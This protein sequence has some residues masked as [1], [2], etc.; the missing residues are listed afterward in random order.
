MTD[1]HT[2]PSKPLVKQLLIN[3]L[4][5]IPI[6]VIPPCI[7][8]G[9]VVSP[10]TNAFST[11]QHCILRFTKSDSSYLP[12]CKV[13]AARSQDPSAACFCFSHLVTLAYI[14]EHVLFFLLHCKICSM[15][16]FTPNI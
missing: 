4:C 9:V 8:Q 2:S 13:G 14:R 12:Q 1:G 11:Y 16:H 7:V 3:Q 15:L 5:I 10:L 6:F